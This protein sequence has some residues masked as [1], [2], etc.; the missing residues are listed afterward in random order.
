MRRAL[1]AVLFTLESGSLRQMS[2]QERLLTR[3]ASLVM[4]EASVDQAPLGI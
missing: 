3:F 2:F 1:G 4:M